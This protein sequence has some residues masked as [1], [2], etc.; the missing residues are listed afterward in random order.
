MKAKIQKWGNSLGLRIPKSLA[1][2]VSLTDGSEIEIFVDED[3]IIIKSKKGNGKP[4]LK[5]LLKRY[6]PEHKNEELDLGKSTGRET[7]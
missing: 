3:C 1:N 6:K 5:D 7:W 2:E 4:R